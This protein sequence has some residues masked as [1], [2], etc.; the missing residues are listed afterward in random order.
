MFVKKEQSKTRILYYRDSKGRVNYKTLIIED[1]VT[2][3]MHVFNSKKVKSKDLL[4]VELFCF[5]RTDF[6]LG[7]GEEVCLKLYKGRPAG[8]WYMV[9]YTE[10]GE[11]LEFQELGLITMN[12]AR[13]HYGKFLK[14]VAL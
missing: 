4:K 7:S 11:E 1:G 10:R 12:Q 14:E 3:K 2:Y 5:L 13:N 9:M 6:R 8:A